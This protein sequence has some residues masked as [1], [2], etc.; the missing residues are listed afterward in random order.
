[1]FI[2]EFSANTPTPLVETLI[3]GNPVV[4]RTSLVK[5]MFPPFPPT[6]AIPTLLSPVKVI[7]LLFIIFTSVCNAP[8][9]LF[10]Y[11]PVALFPATD[12]VPLFSI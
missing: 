7:N 5:L 3:S 2:F 1:M 8:P 10:A 4:L 6:N 9:L 11:I 12:I